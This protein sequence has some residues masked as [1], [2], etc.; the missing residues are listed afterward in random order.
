MSKCVEMDC[1][2]AILIWP[3]FQSRTPGEGPADPIPNPL[4]TLPCRSRSITTSRL[5][6]RHRIRRSVPPRCTRFIAHSPLID[7]IPHPTTSDVINR[8]D[9][10]AGKFFVEAEDGTFGG[11]VDVAGTATAGM[12]GLVVGGG[13]RCWSVV[14]G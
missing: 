13:A 3:E 1:E 7:E 10:L 6:T 11:R 12:D 2:S 14:G 5:S 8:S 4:D 9:S